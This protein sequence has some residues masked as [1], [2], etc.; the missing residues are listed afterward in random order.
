MCQHIVAVHSVVVVV[1]VA[2][3]DCL[4]SVSYQVKVL[5]GMLWRRHVDHLQH[6]TE[7]EPAVPSDTSNSESSDELTVLPDTTTSEPS[8]VDDSDQPS[9]SQSDTSDNVR[10]Y[11]QRV[12]NPPQRYQ[13]RRKECRTVMN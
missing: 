13:L 4:S 10:R 11:P 8:V 9:Q 1:I 5:D 6:V 7:H 12:R 3:V 2:I